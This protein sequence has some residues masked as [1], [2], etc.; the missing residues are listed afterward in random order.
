[1]EKKDVDDKTT[2]PWPMAFKTFSLFLT[3]DVFWL[4][5][6]RWYEFWWR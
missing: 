2:T 6:R 5:A 3:F 4:F 1:M